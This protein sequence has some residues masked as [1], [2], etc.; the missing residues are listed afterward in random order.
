MSHGRAVPRPR[1]T[2]ATKKLSG[3]PI[4][5]KEC[6]A[7]GLETQVLIPALPVTCYIPISRPP[8][9]ISLCPLL[10]ECLCMCTVGNQFDFLNNLIVYP[11]VT[12]SSLIDFPFQMPSRFPRTRDVSPFFST[13]SCRKTKNSL[14]QRSEELGSN[15]GSTRTVNH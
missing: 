2:S 1:R 4:L 8:E 12:L 15:V 14:E 13:L 9:L 3:L 7:G 6:W 11:F 5:G 10:W